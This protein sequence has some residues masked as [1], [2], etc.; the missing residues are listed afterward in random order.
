MKEHEL[1]KLIANMPDDMDIMAIDE[2]DSCSHFN[3][4]VVTGK[5]GTI[6]LEVSE[7]FETA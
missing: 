6:Y 3:G 7:P 4:N 5:D 1:R 2:E